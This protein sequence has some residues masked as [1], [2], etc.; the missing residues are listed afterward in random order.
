MVGAIQTGCPR[1]RHG[2]GPSLPLCSHGA[3]TGAVF[4]M[5]M[6]PAVPPREMLAACTAWAFD[7]SLCHHLQG[8]RLGAAGTKAA[9]QG[10]GA[11]V[12][13]GYGGSKVPTTKAMVLC[14]SEV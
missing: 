5:W 13:V 10:A 3:L 1:R 7:S 14:R 11:Q 9:R 8:A 4:P 6:G 12:G 2:A